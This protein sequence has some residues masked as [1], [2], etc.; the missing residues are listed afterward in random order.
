MPAKVPPRLPPIIRFTQLLHKHNDPNHRAVRA[1][2]KAHRHDPV[3]L[4]RAHAV[5]KAYNLAATLTA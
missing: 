3:F 1:H 2:V 5:T 4:H